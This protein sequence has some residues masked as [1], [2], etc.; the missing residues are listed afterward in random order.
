MR[1]L[2][3]SL[4]LLATSMVAAAPSSGSRT[5][6]SSGNQTVGTV[7]K[8]VVT[9]VIQAPVTN[10]GTVCLGGSDVTTSK[11]ACLLAGMAE[12]GSPQGNSNAY[13]LGSIYM[14]CTVNTDVVTWKQQ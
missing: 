6:P 10:T 8:R 5:C 11:G 12:F 7:N 2:I 1:T 4:L 14:A 3:L 13:D 9:Y